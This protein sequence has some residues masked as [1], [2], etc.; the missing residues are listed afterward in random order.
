MIKFAIPLVIAV[1]LFLFLA[2]GLGRDSREIPSPLIGKPAPEF[3]LPAL[4]EPQRTV[5]LS[6]FA[7]QV[8]AFNI[9]GSW[10]VACRDEHEVLL[11][12]RRDNQIP[13]I[14]LNWKDTEAEATRWLRTLGDPYV[15]TA[16]D[17]VGD[18]A[19]D[20]GVYGAP[21]T[22]L[23]SADGMILHKHIGP[24]TDDIWRDEFL[25]RVAQ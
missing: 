15:V 21:E 14:G 19:I 5:A 3:T 22:F 12:I 7:G 8:F 16:F 2:S 10:C 18:V 23:V 4:A 11:R 20:W 9:W 13:L 1:V 25:A 6:D 17:P 24:L